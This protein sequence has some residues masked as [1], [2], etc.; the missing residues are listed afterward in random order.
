MAD[1]ENVAEIDHFEHRHYFHYDD[2]LVYKLPKPVLSIKNENRNILIFDIVSSQHNYLM[3]FYDNYNL[4][5]YQKNTYDD[6][7]YILHFQYILPIGELI[8][9]TYTDEYLYLNDYKEKNSQLIIFSYESK[10]DC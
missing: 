2:G 6:K 5:F 9:F 10:F 4:E 1:L 7:K 3:I 8:D